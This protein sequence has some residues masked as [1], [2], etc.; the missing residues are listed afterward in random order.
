MNAII[1]AAGLGI[2]LSQLTNAIPKPLL[3]IKGK[4]IIEY[5]IKFL[6]EMGVSSIVIVTGHLSEQFT[7]LTGKYKQIELIYNDLYEKYNNFY[8]MYLARH[9][10]IGDTYVI[11]GDVFFRRN[12]LLNRMDRSCY[13]IGFKEQNLKEWCPEVDELD[14]VINIRITS[15]SAFILTGISYWIPRDAQIIRGLLKYYYQSTNDWRTMYW[16]DVPRLHLDK[17]H[18]DIKK[19]GENNWVEIDTVEDYNTLQSKL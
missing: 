4:P 17:L 5:Q 6:K 15:S 11:D 19:I 12:F 9:Y 1:L 8:S 3:P 14:R 16:D 2:R 7:Y 13:F 18:I 10:F